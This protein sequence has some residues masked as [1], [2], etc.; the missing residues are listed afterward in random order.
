MHLQAL[1]AWIR[2]LEIHTEAGSVDTVSLE[3]R[4]NHVIEFIQDLDQVCEVLL[5]MNLHHP[6]GERLSHLCHTRYC[7]I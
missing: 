2:D 7:T 5:F 6:V 3:V 4:N 1:I